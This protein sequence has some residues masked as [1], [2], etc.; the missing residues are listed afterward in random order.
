MKEGTMKDKRSIERSRVWPAGRAALVSA[1]VVALCLVT[2]RAFGDGAG[3]TTRVSVTSDGI[4][5][6]N[7]SGGPDVSPDGRYVA[8]LSSA[9]NLV[10]GDT[11]GAEDVFVH[12]RDTG[13]TIRVSVASDGSEANA[14][15][16]DGHGSAPDITAD[17]RYV[18]FH[19]EA[20]NLVPGDT[21]GAEDVFVHDLATGG[22]TQVSIAS[23]A[24]AGNQLSRDPAISEDGR[25]VAFRS[26]ASN[27]VVGDSNDV[28]DVFVHDRDTG[29]T[30]RVSASS[31]GAQANDS[32]VTPAISGDGRY[33]AF[34]SLAGNL[35]PGDSND[36]PDVFVH[37]RDSGETVRVSVSSDGTESVFAGSALPVISSDG[38]Y[39]AFESGYELVPGDMNGTF[40]VFVHDSATGETTRVSVA[41][42]GTERDHASMHTAISP[43]GRYIAF[44]SSGN[45]VPGDTNGDEDVFVHDRAIG[46][47]TRASVASDG[48]EANRYSAIGIALSA[49][50]RDV[51]FTSL[52]D[53]LVPGDTNGVFDVFVRHRDPAGIT[54]TDGDGISDEDELTRGTDPTNPDTDGDGLSD[55][56][57]VARGTDPTNP[58]TDGDG[59]PD[60]RELE[61]GTD[62][63]DADSDA[64]GLPD[65]AELEAGLDPTASDSDGDGLVDGSDV[66]F[67]QAGVAS[68]PDSAFKGPG[69]RSALH[70]HLEEVERLLLSGDTAGALSKL[71]DLR[72]HLDGCGLV[73]DLNDWITD[74]EHQLRVRAL[75]DTLIANLEGAAS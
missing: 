67:V 26:E 58:D 51:V 38:R 33:I 69:H 3:T 36:V 31:D 66:E 45:F 5:S 14:G 72:K 68:V 73:A 2:S 53:N 7:D 19:S 10:P 71:Q 4:Q 30:V 24:T 9:T 75:L 41:S 50:G 11:N 46:E 37:D 62:P 22:T 70:S 65:G 6:N 8:F 59:I 16:Q 74:C 21:N 39:V 13:E 35:V 43:D 27:L 47:T 1:S 54:D 57:E 42:D 44:S 64:D 55:G 25:Y 20:T 17:G 48:T 34:T 56:D 63:T 49:A 61:I 12:D 52:A 40:D 18:A 28:P 15:S 32:S 23:D 60:G 29:E